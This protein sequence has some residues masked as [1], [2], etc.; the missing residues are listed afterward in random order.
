M[1]ITYEDKKNGVKI[2]FDGETREIISWNM[3]L[4]YEDTEIE[5]EFAYA[6]LAVFG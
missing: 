5:E 3:P 6:R 2:V 1:N 4:S